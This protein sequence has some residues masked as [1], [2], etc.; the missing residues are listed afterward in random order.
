MPF[1]LSHVS[2]T[3]RSGLN[4]SCCD[5]RL[6]LGTAAFQAGYGITNGRKLSER[7]QMWNLL[8]AAFARGIKKI[9]T[10]ASS[11]EP[12]IPIQELGFTPVL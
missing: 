6:V 8:E 12:R 7:K 10:A 11:F 5:R 1:T 4:E 9:D 3:A 2:Q